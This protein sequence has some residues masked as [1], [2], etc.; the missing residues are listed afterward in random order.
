MATLLP[1]A[2]SAVCLA[3]NFRVTA[4]QQPLKISAFFKFIFRGDEVITKFYSSIGQID[5]PASVEL[6]YGYSDATVED[7]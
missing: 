1:L 6:F 5:S 2:S 7:S 3:I 4:T